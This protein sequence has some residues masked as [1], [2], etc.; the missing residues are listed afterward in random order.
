MA[1]CLADLAGGRSPPHDVALRGPRGNGKT[2][3]LNWFERRCRPCRQG[4]HSAAVPQPEYGP[5]RPLVD[6][7]LP[8]TGIKRILPR[9]LGI[10]GGGEAEWTVSSPS[11]AESDRAD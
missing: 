4:G 3:L 11:A 8:A 7:L 9:K 10:A 1:R 2:V 6:A 5:S